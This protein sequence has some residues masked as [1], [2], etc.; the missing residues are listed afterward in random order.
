MKRTLA[1]LLTLIFALSALAG[2]AAPAVETPTSQPA[3]AVE[4]TVAPA[5][6]STAQAPAAEPEASA[7]RIFTDSVGREVEIP[8]N[9]D[10]IAISGPLAQLTL[11]SLAPDKLVGIANEWDKTAQS[12]LDAKYY[13]LPLLGQLYGGKGELNL[14]TL[15][16]S[17]A[18]IVID[19]GEPKATIVEDLD[20]LSE[21]TGI[22]FVHITLTLETAGEAYRKLGE[23]LNMKD[24][25]EAL[26]SYCEETYAKIK[27]IASK[28]EKK[29]LLYCLGDAGLNVIANGSYHAEVI[30]LLANNLAV[31]AEPSSKG[32]GNEVDMEQLLLWNPDVI[33]FA[34]DSVY[35]SVGEDKTWQELKA[36]KDGTYYEAPYGP[37]NW[38]G[39][40]PSVQRYLGML[41]M[42]KLL[43]PQAAD[44]DLFDEVD[45]YFNLFYHCSITKEQY[46]GM[47]ANSIGK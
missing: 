39:F 30:D 21:Q 4:A 20:G 46:D 25:A 40:P 13:N 12:F 26:A 14:E 31:V 24:E 22:P 19:V 43:Y 42:T 35:A 47:V 27:D 23:L 33:I 3:P 28:V 2:C 15:L 10:K 29:N 34:P 9:I 45:K 38:M 37:Y 18:Q 36:I 16:A 1:F 6:E 44:Y 8:V 5:S 32:S 11:F 17:G 41:W 7:T